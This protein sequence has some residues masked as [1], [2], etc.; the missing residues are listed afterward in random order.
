MSE[1]TFLCIQAAVGT[2]G[3]LLLASLCVLAETLFLESVPTKLL[4]RLLAGLLLLLL[5]ATSY[6]LLLRHKH[7]FIPIHGLL[8]NID[9]EFFCP[10]CESPLAYRPD[11]D[12]EQHHFHCHKCH[13]S[14]FPD[15]NMTK[16]Q[17]LSERK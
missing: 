11:T 16:D 17:L 6:A 13:R 5:L 4:L 15:N 9:W 10:A 1:K 2:T 7:R 14:V 12:K 8:R 3:L